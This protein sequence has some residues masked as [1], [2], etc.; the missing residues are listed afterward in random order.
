MFWKQLGIMLK[1][2]HI[3]QTRYWKAT[4]SQVLLT[5]ALFLTLLFFLQQ[6]DYT[7]Q[8]KTITSPPESDLQGVY[9]CQGRSLTEPSSGGPPLPVACRG[10]GPV[11]VVLGVCYCV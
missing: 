2:N 7:N 8:R 3:L 4:L 11:C 6:A 5:P 1:R 10:A 9:A